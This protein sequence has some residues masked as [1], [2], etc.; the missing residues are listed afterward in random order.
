MRKTMH[1]QK[2]KFD[3]DIIKENQINSGAEEFSE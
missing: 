2:E 3:K 1:E